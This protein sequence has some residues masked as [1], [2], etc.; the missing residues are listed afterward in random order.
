MDVWRK[1]GAKNK[2][3]A[4]FIRINLRYLCVPIFDCVLHFLK[5]APPG[6]IICFKYKL[7]G[8]EASRQKTWHCESPKDLLVF[9]FQVALGA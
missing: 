6:S 3:A 2:V 1:F 5:R 8:Y 9:E 7:N 4:V